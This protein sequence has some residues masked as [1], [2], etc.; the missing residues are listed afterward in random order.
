[1]QTIGRMMAVLGERWT[2]VVL[3]EVFNGVRRFDD[4]CRHSG[5]P[6]Q[7]LSNRPA[8][9]VDQ[10]IL[11]REP[12]RGRA[13]PRHRGPSRPGRHAVRGQRRGLSRLANHAW[14]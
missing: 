9:L 12:Y 7:A 13:A 8:L 2:F 3:R 11:R 4:I 5:I 1:M 14:A 6:R 10:A